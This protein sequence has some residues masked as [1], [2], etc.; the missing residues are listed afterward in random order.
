YCFTTG[1]LDKL[2]PKEIEAT[3]ALLLC[4]SQRLQN[5]R[6]LILAILIN[7]IFGIF[8]GVQSL[9]P[10]S[11]KSSKIQNLLFQF[12]LSLMNPRA[13]IYR[14]DLAS[15]QLF[16][17]RFT[18]GR[19]LNKL[20]SYSYVAPLQIQPRSHY[21]FITHKNMHPVISQRIKKLV[22]YYPL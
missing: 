10:V 7:G 8:N 18:L 19:V 4:H 14:S 12:F 22:G 1:L 9:L 11:V 5:F 2:P 16:S 13:D 3:C 15:A 21:L 6:F 17:D 20:N